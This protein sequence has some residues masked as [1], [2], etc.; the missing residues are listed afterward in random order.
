MATISQEVFV[1]LAKK[2]KM[3]YLFLRCKST[4]VYE[5][6]AH[7]NEIIDILTKSPKFEHHII[8]APHHL[9]LTHP[10]LVAPL[11]NAFLSKHFTCSK[12]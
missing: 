6:E 3:P 1:E 11:I 10:E 4:P 8:D 5:L 2:L 9:H 7:H 12:L